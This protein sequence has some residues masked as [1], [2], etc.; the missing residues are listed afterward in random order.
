[1][2]EATDWR[3]M[4][5][6]WN[7]AM[8]AS[9]EFDR[10]VADR[11]WA[12][13]P[14]ASEEAIAGAERRLGAKLPESYKAFVRVSNGWWVPARG[15]GE[16][17]LRVWGTEDIRLLREV[18]PELVET[19]SEEVLEEDPE[20]I[21]V[22]PRSH[23]RSVLQ[24][25]G[26]DD[27]FYLLNPLME[28]GPGECQ[29]AFFA[30]WVPGEH[31]YPSFGVMMARLCEEYLGA[32]PARGIKLGIPPDEPIDEPGEFIERLKMLG[33]FRFVST[34]RAAEMIADYLE[35]KSRFKG[36]PLPGRF[37]SP[38]AAILT[39]DC[40]RVARLD[41]ERL[42]RERGAYAIAAARP[43]LARAGVELGQLREEDTKGSY[44]VEL[45]GVS[46]EFF[47]VR[48]GKPAIPGGE[49]AVNVA[50]AVIQ[51]TATLVNRVLVAKR[52]R[53]RFATMMEM[54]SLIG[55]VVPA[56]VM[57]DEEMAY[58]MMWSPAIHNYCRPTR[59]DV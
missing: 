9:G 15:G 17:P 18:Q 52:R 42:A 32:H 38:G 56:L 57:L 49:H 14:P 33:F 31:C 59:G 26:D 46:R 2:S 43:L 8:I 36:A 3:K 53:E 11:R 21:S 25:S 54:S 6:T 12:G 51:E 39:D 7:G 29:A 20:D 30:N 22:I 4:L 50:M 10:V 16:G 24:I 19:W 44:S 23:H 13:F 28:T 58:L 37:A 45:E 47:R 40:G 41:S 1:M 5:R 34:E 27:G 55:G 35:T 48:K